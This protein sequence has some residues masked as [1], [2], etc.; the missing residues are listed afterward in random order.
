MTGVGV[1]S[2]TEGT[3]IR[4]RISLGFIPMAPLRPYELISKLLVDH[5]QDM[6][7]Q[8]RIAWLEQGD[9]HYLVACLVPDQPTTIFVPNLL[10]AA[11]HHGG[12]SDASLR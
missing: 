10:T 8:G 7:H 12:E 2:Y 4:Q 1:A 5:L 3:S 6:T 11:Y 9:L